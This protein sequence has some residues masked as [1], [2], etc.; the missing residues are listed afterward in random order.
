MA[1]VSRH[2]VPV[3]GVA[4][5]IA[6]L[7]IGSCLNYIIPNPQRVFVYVYSASVLPGMVPWF[8]I[9]ISQLRFRR[10]HKAAIA[11]HPFRSILFPWANYVTMAFLICVLIGMYF[12]EDT[13]MSLFVGIIFMLAVTAIYKVLALI[14]TG[15]RINWRNKQQN[16]QTVTKR[17]IYLKGTRQRVGSPYY[18][19]RNGAK[20]P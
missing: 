12:N 15:K 6:I 9:L 19:P 2:G 4:V 20:R 1:K 10:A 13:R 7:L 3:A 5:S 14:A 17:A 18:P 11:S 8:V 16:A